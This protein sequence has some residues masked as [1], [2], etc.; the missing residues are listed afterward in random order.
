MRKCAR[1]RHPPTDGAARCCRRL[2][3]ALLLFLGALHA[4]QPL[5]A[6]GGTPAAAYQHTPSLLVLALGTPHL[7]GAWRLLLAGDEGAAHDLAM[8]QDLGGDAAR[9]CLSLC[10]FAERQGYQR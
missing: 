2:A 5:G 6:A 4:V 1:R 8:R 9:A 3:C 10:T 7:D